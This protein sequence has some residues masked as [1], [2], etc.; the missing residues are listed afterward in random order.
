MNAQMP[1]AFLVLQSL[2]LALGIGLL[3]GLE[4]GWHERAAADG[5]RVAGVRT[6][7]LMG[8]AGGLTGVLANQFGGLV[9]AAGVFALGMI[10]AVSYWLSAQRDQSVGIT[11][12]IASFLT[13]ALGA[14]A[15]SG[16][17]Y[18]AVAAGVFTM[19]L[20]GLKSVLH[21]G[22]QKLSEQEL[23][24]TFKLLLLA[25]VIGWMVLLL[26]GLSFVGY[27]AM[28]ILG[29]R[30]GLLLTSVLGG[31]VSSTALTI[32]SARFSRE[33]IDLIH[34]LAIGI[35]VAST[36]LFPRVLIEVG[37]VNAD[38][39]TDLI[40]PIVA[41][42]IT[43]SLGAFIGW[44]LDSTPESMNS[45]L[46]SSLK[47]PLELSAA[48][49]FTLVLIAI[50]LLAHGLQHSLGDSGIYVLAAVSGLA[51]VDALSLSLSKMA[52]QGQIHAHVATQAIVLAIVV[53]T[54][55][56]TVLAFAI[57]G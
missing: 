40:P 36:I 27:F 18:V 12:E 16:Y 23:F 25:L 32:T 6:F 48:L 43:A 56:K 49:R 47:N 15:V 22:L 28:R 54:L 44:R 39:L 24:A 42:M 14:I 21:A 13:F 10:L 45:E 11:T 31:L 37:F 53:N 17:A 29:S 41:M 34:T 8:L 57:G 2:G 46:E 4:R 33:R 55:V 30:R 7:G 20:L 9:L 50:M 26:A 19:I 3:I 38:L 51:D 5:Q 1:D 52:G 35:M